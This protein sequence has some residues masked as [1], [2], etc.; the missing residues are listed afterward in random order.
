MQSSP[1]AG[2]VASLPWVETGLQ[3]V[4]EEV[5]AEKLMLRVP[6]YTRLWEIDD[7]SGEEVVLSSWSYSMQRAEEII[8]DYG[9]EIYFDDYARQ[10]VAE[11]RKGGL[12]YKM[13]L[14]DAGSMRERL[15]LIEKYQLAGLAAWRRGLETPDIWDLI[16]EFTSSMN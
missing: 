7:N 3:R 11:Y 8:A 15:N 16:E 5:P 4:L 10:H 1:T 14:E 13:W 2:S 9:A 12:L 6:F